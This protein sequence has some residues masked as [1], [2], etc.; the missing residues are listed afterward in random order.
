MGFKEAKRKVLEA[1]STGAYQHESR[2]GIDV[3]NL[4]A[5]GNVSA[6][7]V[8]GLIRKCNGKDHEMSAHDMMRSITVHV[9]K[10]D[11]WYIKFYFIDPDTW[12]I[13]VHQ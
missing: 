7:F 13:S 5:M 4:L 2:K 11:G 10:K 1:L 3:K 8:S 12:F 9:L 6:E